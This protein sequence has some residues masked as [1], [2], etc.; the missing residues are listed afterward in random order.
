MAGGEAGKFS[1]VFA[2]WVSAGRWA[3]SASAGESRRCNETGRIVDPTDERVPIRRTLAPRAATPLSG[4]VALLDIA[5]PRGDV[6][7]DRL[8]R[9]S[10]AT[11]CPASSSS[12]IANRPSP[13]RRP[14]SCAARSRRRATS[15][16]KR[17]PIEGHVQRAVCTTQSGSKLTASPRWWSRRRRSLTRREK[18]AARAGIAGSA[19]RFRAASDPGCDR[20]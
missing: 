18:Q 9:A 14:T 4:R 16:S 10:A 12:A 1:A 15:L 2:G 13:N 17:S 7:I 6:L 19:A 11:G 3:R 5:K 20:R 8:A